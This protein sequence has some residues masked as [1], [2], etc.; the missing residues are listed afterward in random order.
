MV[1]VCL[2]VLV[3]LVPCVHPVEVLGLARPVLVMPPVHLQATHRSAADA[4]QRHFPIQHRSRQ[5]I[6]TYAALPLM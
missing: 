2:V 5:S 1:I 3:P 4:C 6:W